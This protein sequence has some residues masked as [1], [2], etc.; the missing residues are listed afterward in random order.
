MNGT[1]T[2]VFLRATMFLLS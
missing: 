1:I 2:M